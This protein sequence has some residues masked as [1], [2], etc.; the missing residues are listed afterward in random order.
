MNRSSKIFCVI[1]LFA[2]VLM[3]AQPGNAQEKTNTL[4]YVGVALVAGCAAYAMS[5][6]EGEKTADFYGAPMI[7]T[8]AVLATG[9][10]LIKKSDKPGTEEMTA[11]LN[12]KQLLVAPVVNP[13]RKTYGL[14]IGLKF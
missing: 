5:V 6:G 10:V 2:F 1:T 13:I 14:S 11:A 8:T 12:R 7:I 9:W 4:K 3:F